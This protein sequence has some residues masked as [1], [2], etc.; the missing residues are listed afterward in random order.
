[1]ALSNSSRRIVLV[2]SNMPSPHPSEERPAGTLSSFFD[3]GDLYDLLAGNIPYGLDFYT[4]LARGAGG[5]VLDIA[6]GTGRILLPCQLAGVDIEGLDLYEPMLRRLRE[7][8]ARLN[9]EPRV[10]GADMSDFHLPR[11]FSL[12]MIPFNAFVHNMTQDAQIRCLVRC[13]EHLLPGGRLV[14]DTGFWMLEM[15][16]VPASTRVL[17][18]EFAHPDSG[19]TVRVYDTR[20]FDQ[21]EQTQYSLYEVEFLAADGSVQSVHRSEV[22]CRYIYKQEMEL[23]L[24]VAGYARWEIHGDFNG[25]PVSRECQAMIVKAWNAQAPS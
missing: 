4:E 25:N 13:R 7:K 22:S 11:R 16:G 14:F 3:D 9:L 18:G 23:L 8:A 17:E 5:P 20:T 15:V 2:N 1:V 10:H 19:L 6:C 21:V 24:R 12:I